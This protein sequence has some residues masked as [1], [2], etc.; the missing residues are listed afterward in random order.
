MLRTA[1]TLDVRQRAREIDLLVIPYN[2][3]TLVPHA[4]RMVTETIAPGAFDGIERQ[5]N[6]IAVNRDHVIERTVGRATAFDPR[7]SRGLCA[8][9]RIAATDL[10]DETL[11]LAAEDCLDASAAFRPVDD[12]L[13]WQTRD[14]YRITARLARAH[15]H[16][17]GRRV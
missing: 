7:D 16:G 1:Q 12:G 10:G 3:P 17:T 15:R 11:A 9:A 8:T 2:R 6:R 13:R 4:G 14:S 5:T